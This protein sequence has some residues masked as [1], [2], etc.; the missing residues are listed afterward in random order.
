MMMFLK[1]IGGTSE[2][3]RDASR[4]M[5]DFMQPLIDEGRLADGWTSVGRGCWQKAE[6]TP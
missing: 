4:R 2:W 5:Y 6:A 3:D 1:V